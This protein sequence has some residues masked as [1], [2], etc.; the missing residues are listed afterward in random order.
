M[1]YIWSRCSEL[2]FWQLDQSTISLIFSFLLP[3]F[4]HP[5]PTEENNCL[6]AKCSTVFTSVLL[7]LSAVWCSVESVQSFL[8]HFL[9]KQ[10][11]AADK[12]GSTENDNC[13]SVTMRNLCHTHI[14]IWLFPMLL[15]QCYIAALNT[16]T[17]SNMKASK[18]LYPAG[19]GGRHYKEGV[20]R[21]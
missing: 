11:P 12:S 16:L 10:L 3:L 21:T 4:L 2:C 7:I 9:W 17:N 5:P 20:C 14:V 1:W 19:V 18:T 13:G 6:V 8:E 15:Q